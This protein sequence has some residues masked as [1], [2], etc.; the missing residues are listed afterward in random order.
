MSDSSKNNRIIAVKSRI[1]REAAPNIPERVRH[2]S[3]LQ[4]QTTL[5]LACALQRLT[6]RV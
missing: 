1:L 2:A 4:T 3:E 6:Q 5:A